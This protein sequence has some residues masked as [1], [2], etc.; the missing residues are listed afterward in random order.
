MKLIQKRSFQ[1]TLRQKISLRLSITFLF[2]LLA[3]FLGIGYSFLSLH[4]YRQGM[5][6]VTA[7]DMAQAATH[8]LSRNNEE[9]TTLPAEFHGLHMTDKW[10]D[11]PEKIR[12]L[13]PDA[14]AKSGDLVIA[15]NSA[16]LKK[17]DI[18]TFALLYIKDGR[19]LYIAKSHKH[20]H[21]PPRVG[22]SYS[23][24][25]RNLLFITLAAA[26]LAALCTRFI[27]N[28]IAKPVTA[29]GDWARSLNE[30]NLQEPPPDFTY[31]ELN[32]LADLI[33]N[34]LSA[35]Q[36]GLE[37]EHTFLRNASHELRTPITVIR[38]NIELVHKLQ[39]KEGN[40]SRQKKQQAIDRIDRASLN[41]KHMTETLLWL[42]RDEMNTLP[43]H[44]V[45]LDRLVTEITGELQYLVIGKD[46]EIRLETTPFSQELPETVARIVLGNLIRNAFQHTQ[47]GNI[48]IH[49]EG[50]R[51]TISN[52]QPEQST[53]ENDLGF[54]LGL[55]LTRQ[56]TEK[57]SW[58]YDTAYD[59]ARNT[60]NIRLQASPE[61]EGEHEQEIPA[62]K[63]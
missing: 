49:Q 47:K 50:N 42:S 12:T 22:K 11:M 53:A 2:I 44:T 10:E 59:T 9:I 40:T 56:L 60:V 4:Y 35:V 51:I 6:A 15:D 30:T 57:L 62:P 63:S 39:E 17:P 52:P 5:D 34:S 23:E 18:V 7:S 14:P 45:S 48:V 3:V 27:F 36:Q 1:D 33:R 21:P 55:R 13:L 54:G 29:L 38:N 26:L 37:R 24:N 31:P 46:V 61:T 20:I 19:P 16:W 8:F 25:L 41:M 58:P 43:Q 28:H 32:S